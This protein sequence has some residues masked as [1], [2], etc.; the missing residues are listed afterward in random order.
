MYGSRISEK[1][2]DL[3]HRIP[4]LIQ[5]VPG[6]VHPEL[7]D[8]FARCQ[9]DGFF[10]TG[11]EI[12]FRHARLVSQF[13]DRN[14]PVKMVLDIGQDRLQ[15]GNFF[16]PVLSGGRHL[17]VPRVPPAF[18]RAHQSGQ[19]NVQTS[20]QAN[21]GHAAVLPVMAVGVAKQAGVFPNEV[22]RNN[23]R[24]VEVIQDAKM[25][26]DAEIEMDINETASFHGRIRRIGNVRI[27]EDD[28]AGPGMVFPA[29]H[30]NADL[31]GLHEPE[32]I[33]QMGLAFRPAGTVGFFPAGM[34]AQL[35]VF[36]QFVEQVE[37]M[38]GSSRYFQTYNCKSIIANRFVAAKK[39]Y[40]LT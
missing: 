37:F 8:I 21:G 13:P 15:G 17:K 18:I 20:F 29:F 22:S 40:F 9:P 19:K 30:P 7:V 39:S 1:I 11:D 28:V 23:S 16:A 5:I 25:V 4:F 38:H 14:R 33:V 31:S 10:E 27:K 3:P 2:R 36:G 24:Q 35:H 34:D 32:V 12:F 6:S 26:S